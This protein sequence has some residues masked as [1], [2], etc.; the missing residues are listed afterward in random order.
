MREFRVGGTLVPRPANAQFSSFSRVSFIVHTPESGHVIL[1]HGCAL[2]SQP[3]HT[4][5]QPANHTR[6]AT[7]NA[8]RGNANRYFETAVPGK[9]E[10][11]THTLILINA[12][13][14]TN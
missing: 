11:Q 13:G 5:S 1:V 4:I 6:R 14:A 2:F 10:L 3:A 7:R 8:Q 9:E 12:T